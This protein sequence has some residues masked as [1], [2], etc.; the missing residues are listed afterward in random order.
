[1]ISLNT[2]A[3]HTSIGYEFEFDNEDETNGSSELSFELTV[4]PQAFISGF[5][6][7]IDGEL[8]IGETIE[9]KQAKQEYVTAKQQHENAI[10]I[11]Q[12]FP[13]IPNV[14]RVKTNIDSQSK[15]VLTICIEQYLT[16]K[17]NYNTLN[18]EIIKAF[19]KYQITQ[20]CKYIQLNIDIADQRSIYDMQLIFPS[21]VIDSNTSN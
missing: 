18:I 6:A 2:Y 4:D 8:F 7:V 11:S 20:K 10:L 1:M 14:F 13:D 17:L 19:H 21:I 12:P 16:K 3:I 5:T 9:K 15:I